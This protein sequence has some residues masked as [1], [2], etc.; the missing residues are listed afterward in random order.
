MIILR[1]RVNSISELRKLPSNF[2]V[3]VDVQ[4]KNGRLVTGH[5]PGEEEA[6]F[7]AWLS[8]YDHE[9]LAL[10]VKQEG[11]ET[12]I[13]EVLGEYK[14]ENYFMFDV[15]FPM[16]VRLS[17]NSNSKI[18]L[19]VSDL[20]PFQVLENFRGK[21]EWIWLDAFSD[22]DYLKEADMK[23]H[24]FKTCLVSPELHL[25]RDSEKVKQLLNELKKINIDMDAVCTKN[26][27]VW[28]KGLK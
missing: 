12:S 26:V 25:N 11:I 19:R 17:N 6:D 16:V 27:D 10:N 2:G 21:V 24:G 7:H 18:A 20:E 28:A 8:Y 1:H 23:F 5:D 9:L 3:E 14:I 13:V 4:I 15:S 22:Y